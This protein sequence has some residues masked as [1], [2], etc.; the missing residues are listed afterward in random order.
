MAETGQSCTQEPRNLVDQTASELNFHI[1]D[2]VRKAG[3]DAW[4][5]AEGCQSQKQRATGTHLLIPVLPLFLECCLEPRTP[6]L[7]PPARFMVF[8][9]HL[10]LVPA[11]KPITQITRAVIMSLLHLQQL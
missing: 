10:E 6:Y 4:V 3:G 1:Q 7:G 9:F 2:D 8:P 5:L 11:D